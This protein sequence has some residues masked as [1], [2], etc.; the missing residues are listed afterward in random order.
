MTHVIRI[1]LVLGAIL[2]AGA[3]AIAQPLPVS[4]PLDIWGPVG[5]TAAARDGHLLYLGGVNYVGPATGA[6]AS[7][8]TTTAALVARAPSLTGSVSAVH[9][10][11]DGGWAV[12]GTLR[13]GAGGS[14]R[15]LRV[16]AAGVVV[17]WYPEISG[18]VWAMASDATTFPSRARSGRWTARRAKVPRRSIWLPGSCAGGT[19]R[20]RR[21][22]SASASWRSSFSRG[23]SSSA[24]P[25][26]RRMGSR[27]RGSWP[28]TASRPP[29]CRMR[30]RRCTFAR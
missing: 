3:A 18:S 6:L 15:L 19:R 23:P 20:S 24:A 8:D 22:L 7:L 17:P 30:C 13:V 2:T 21:A 11:G 16:D 12:A 1:W 10:L 26:T 9:A 29:V 14:Q 27:P 25:S 28:W 4:A 5:V